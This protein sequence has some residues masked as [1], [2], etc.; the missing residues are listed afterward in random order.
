[1]QRH[2]K[3]RELALKFNNESIYIANKVKPATFLSDFLLSVFV[4]RV[5]TLKAVGPGGPA[6]P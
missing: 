2:S 5:L 3:E 4:L 1:M 6:S